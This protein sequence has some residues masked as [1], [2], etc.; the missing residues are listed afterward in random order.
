MEEERAEL[1]RGEVRFYARPRVERATILTFDDV[2][3]LFF[4]LRRATDGTCRRVVVGK[5]RMPAREKQWAYVDRVGASFRE[6]LED[7][8]SE[9]YATKTYGLR[10]QEGADE[11]ASGRYVI[12]SHGAHAHLEIELEGEES[13]LRA[14]LRLVASATYVAAVFNPARF[15][16]EAQASMFSE[17]SLFPEELEAKFAGRR[18]APLEPAFLDYEGAEI[19]LIGAQGTGHDA[20]IEDISDEHEESVASA[21]RQRRARPGAGA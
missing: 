4:V 13:P 12:A 17:P 10:Y 11:I 15:E 6:V 8:G 7:V 1:E 9:T 19:V 2:Q 16:D 18:F 21:A 5:K 3:R 14:M 20:R